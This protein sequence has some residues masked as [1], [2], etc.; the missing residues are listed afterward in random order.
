MQI[1]GRDLDDIDIAFIC[2]LIVVIGSIGFL[3]W[4]GIRTDG[5]PTSAIMQIMHALL[6]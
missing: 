4:D 2:L 5:D 6:D 1:G 3:V